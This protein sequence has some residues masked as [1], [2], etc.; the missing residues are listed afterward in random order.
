MRRFGRKA[1]G[2]VTPLIILAGLALLSPAPAPAMGPAGVEGSSSLAVGG[3][4]VAVAGRLGVGWLT[5][6]STESVYETAT[7]R[8]LSELVW[9]LDSILMLN[10]GAS[11]APTPWLRLNADLWLRLNDGSGAMDDYDYLLPGYGYTHWS[12]SE[13]ELNEGYIVDLNAAFPVLRRG[14]A[15]LDVL[16]GYRRDA[17]EWDAKG[18]TFVYSLETLRDTVG[19]FPDGAT[20]ITYEQWYDVPY[21]GVSLCSR[22]ARLTLSG[23]VVYSPLVSANDK[24]THHFRDL[25]FEQDFDTTTMFGF[26]LGLGY[27]LTT[28]LA[29]QGRFQYQQYDEAQGST[30]I[31]DRATGARYVYG[32]DAAGTEHESSLLSLGL[33]YSF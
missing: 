7:G 9:D 18:G 29:L 8:K 2:G 1:A 10:A 4:Q 19:T 25:V 23:R 21:L 14:D 20:G 16:V 30:T 13:V 15:E 32:G 24:D 31:T 3:H 33:Q 11:I 27:D 12:H 22:L 28:A 5:G 26:E 6:E 17:W